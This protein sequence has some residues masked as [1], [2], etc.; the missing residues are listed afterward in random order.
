MDAADGRAPRPVAVDAMGGDQAPRV[1][2]EG[3]LLAAREFGQ[4]VILVGD[5]SA[6][7]AEL[8]RLGPPAG[9]PVELR[10][11]SEVIGMD[12]SPAAI[13]RRKKDSSLRV[14]LELVRS[15]TAVAAVSAGN[16]GAFMA[17]GSLVLGRLAGVDRAAIATVLPTRAGRAVLID[18][19]ANVD[20]KPHHLV[21]FAIMGEIYA[22]RVLG[23]A[24]PRVGLLTNG[25]EE[26]KGNDVTREAY[27]LLKTATFRFL[28]N[29]EG[30]DV[31]NGNADVIVCDGFVGNVALKV[32]EGL[33]EAVRE[34]VR[35]EIARR[36]LA[37]IG[38]LLI[39]P[40]FRAFE[41][42]VDY[43]EVGGAPLLGLAGVAIVG[44]GGSNA[45]AIKNAIRV[46]ATFAATGVNRAIEQDLARYR[47]LAG[48]GSRPLLEAQ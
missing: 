47:E 46:A 26:G 42:R 23:I 27:A 9:L 32:S 18:A 19:G 2:V 1:V 3:A 10:H 17:L 43:A 12:E 38:Y 40:A 41:R 28:G 33:A 45:R 21:Q 36:W 15:G 22:R 37:R 11:A 31:Y 25:T 7:E 16:S 20:C 39:R 13:L 8:R 29:I 24:T 48:P 6:V 34:M 14:C 4:P 5:R 30:R 35:E 44:H